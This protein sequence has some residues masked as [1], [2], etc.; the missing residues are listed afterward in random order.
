MK[1]D[2][3]DILL[4]CA[5]EVFAEHG[6][7][8]GKIADIVKRAGA[9]IA[10]VNYHYGS[11]DQLFVAALRR[12]YKEADEV[13]PSKGRLTQLIDP[14]AEDKIDALARAVLR[15][16]LDSGKA[17]NFNRIMSKTMHVAG[18]PVEMILNE[19]EKF[20]LKD[21]SL[22]VSEYLDTK[23]EQLISWAVVIFISLATM[24]SKCP[25]GLNERIMGSSSDGFS[26][27]VIQ[28]VIDA[29]VKVIFTSL[30]ALPSQFPKSCVISA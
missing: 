11:K 6:Y 16:S 12:S 24:I 17:G 20:E 19:V 1:Q 26:E 27:E 25:A 9:N 7:R 30:D 14:T 18:S 4:E 5:I 23:C 13:Y 29:Q 10:A 8:D 22:A 28:L 21:L 3:K 2:A 15:R